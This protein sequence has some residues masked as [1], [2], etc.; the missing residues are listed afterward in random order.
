MSMVDKF[1]S[2]ELRYWT[3]SNQV[4]RVDEFDFRRF[5]GISQIR[6]PS[7][8][9]STFLYCAREILCTRFADTTNSTSPFCVT[10]IFCNSCP[11]TMI[12]TSPSYGLKIS[13]TRFSG[14]SN[15]TLPSCT[16]G[17]F[18]ISCPGSTNLISSL[19]FV[20]NFYGWWNLLLLIALRKLFGNIYPGSMNC[21]TKIFS[22]QFSRVD[23]FDFSMLRYGNFLHKFQ[24]LTNLSSQLTCKLNNYYG[25][26]F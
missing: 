16:T 11:W 25:A 15:L 19:I 3:F 8:M 2:H 20:S 18:H 9:Y 21:A 23:E 26:L 7:S 10:W 17:T 6:G 4:S 22:Q 14:S 5:L 1:V 24:D 13:Q 12:S